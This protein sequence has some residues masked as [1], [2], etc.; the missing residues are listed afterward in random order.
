MDFFLRIILAGVCGAVIGIERTRRYKEAGIRTHVIVCCGAAL[1]MIVSKYGFADLVN[2]N[3]ELILGTKG[4]DPAR[5]AAQVVN[6]IGFLGAGVIFRQGASVKGLTTA[7]GIWVTGAIGLSIGTG[8]IIQAVVTTLIIF[9]LQLLFH[10]R[11]FGAD[12]LSDYFIYFVAKD[13]PT[14]RKEIQQFLF[15]YNSQVSDT[16]IDKSE[17]NE[18][19]YEIVFRSEN[20]KVFKEL[21]DYLDKNSSVISRRYTIGQS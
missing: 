16:K 7:A 2:E 4:A 19:T 20:D 21:Q 9:V 11:V 6:G 17:V 15:K 14:L 18:V 5:L 12:S 10:K 13:D 3:R 8:M 1:V